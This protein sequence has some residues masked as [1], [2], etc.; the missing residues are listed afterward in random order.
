M[1]ETHALQVSPAEKELLAKKEI[2]CVTLGEG[3]QKYCEEHRNEPRQR[4]PNDE[5]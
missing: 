1:W 2:Q 5:V 3:F 4:D